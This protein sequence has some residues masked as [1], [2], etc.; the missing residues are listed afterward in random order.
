MHG[1]SGHTLTSAV[2]AIALMSCGVVS[3]QATEDASPAVWKYELTP[4]LW[5]AG[6][7]GSVRVDDRPSAGLAVEQS[8]SDILKVLDFG[9]MGAFEATNGDYGVLFDGVYLR[10]ADEGDIS[11]PLGFTSL[12]GEAKLTQQVYAVAGSYRVL[13]AEDVVDLVGGL[14]YNS[15]KWDVRISA[16]VPVLPA[17]DRRFTRSESWVDPYA[18][19]RILKPLDERWAL[20]GYADIGG[21][22]MGSD[23]SWQ[24]IVG[25]NYAFRPDMS[26][27]FGYRY[28]STDYDDDGFTYDVASAGLYLG[29][30]IGW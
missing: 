2:V 22:G 20:V 21:L 17:P 19:A 30:G 10:V 11:G 4:Y 7:D 9:F 6:L 5:A 1:L 8:F 3:A 14:R 13:D 12:S 24:A 27:K 26:T 28:I 25:A 16:S 29:V 15:V 23:L 18:G